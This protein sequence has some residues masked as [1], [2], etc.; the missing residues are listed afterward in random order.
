MFRKAKVPYTENLGKTNRVVQETAIK[1]DITSVADFRLDGELIGNFTSQ[2][3]LVIGP[4]GRIVGDVTCVNLDI[5]GFFEG[6]ISV[7]ELLCV[8][9]TASITGQVVVK[10]LLVEPGAIFNATCTM[11]Q[12]EG[13]TSD[14]K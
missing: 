11:K 12:V 2:G 4:K 3:K 5:E 7:Q 1:G 8:R 14:G 13:I 10:Q 9:A 6:H